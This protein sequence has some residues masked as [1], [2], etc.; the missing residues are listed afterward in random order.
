MNEAVDERM[1]GLMV[2]GKLT[3][4]CRESHH[5]LNNFSDINQRHF[6]VVLLKKET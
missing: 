6:N 1:N 5:F 3:F 2:V 4:G